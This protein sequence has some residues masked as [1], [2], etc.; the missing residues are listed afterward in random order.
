MVKISAYA[1]ITLE[2]TAGEKTKGRVCRALRTRADVL[3]HLLKRGEDKLEDLKRTRTRIL[4][5]ETFNI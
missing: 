5:A 1:D 2:I 4:I 3:E